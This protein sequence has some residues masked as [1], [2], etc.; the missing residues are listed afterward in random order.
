MELDPAP[1]WGVTEG[2]SFYT[3][4]FFFILPFSHSKKF[5]GPNGSGTCVVTENRKVIGKGWGMAKGQDA[6]LWEL[7]VDGTI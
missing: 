4:P 6:N 3:G 5:T 2:L 7:P 1:S